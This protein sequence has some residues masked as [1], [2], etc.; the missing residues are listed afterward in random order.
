GT[1]GRIH[2]SPS[3]QFLQSQFTRRPGEE[4]FLTGC[5]AEGWLDL[6]HCL[7]H[8]TIMDKSAI[9]VLAASTGWLEVFA[10]LGV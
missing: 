10:A 2:Q 5:V 1:A 3:A 9:S 7:M 8:G 4:W 6:A